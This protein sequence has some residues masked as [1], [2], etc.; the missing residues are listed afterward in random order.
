MKTFTYKSL[1][2]A[3]RLFGIWIFRTAAWWIATG[4]FL[5]L[6][7]RVK[8]SMNFYKALF[9]GKGFIFYI[10]CAWKQFHSFTNVFID[11]FILHDLDDITYTSEGWEHIENAAE[12]KT[13]GIVVMSHMGNWE[14]A[15]H[16]LRRKKINMLLYMGIKQKEQIERAQKESLAKSGLRIIAVMREESSPFDILEGINYL[17]DGGLV[18]LTGDRTWRGDQR[19]IEVSF[20]GYNALLPESPYVL[21]MLSGAPLFFFFAFRTGYK[22]YHFKISPPMYIRA[23]SRIERKAIFKKTAR[24]YAGILEENLRKYPYEWFHFERFIR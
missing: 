19:A 20:L 17:K 5:L 6:P 2:R 16:L 11:R 1:S 22:Q 21:A 12:K 18:S 15:A 7:A 4:Y 10:C 3:S 13:G 8:I 9:P 23:V 14:V 24:Y